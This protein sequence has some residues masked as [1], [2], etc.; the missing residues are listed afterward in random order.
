M[1]NLSNNQLDGSIPM[2]LRQKQEN[3]LLELRTENNPGLCTN[4]NECVDDR[5]K[6]KTLA[7][8]V[9]VVIAVILASLIL[10]VIIVVVVRRQ[11]RRKTPTPPCE[12]VVKEKSLNDSYL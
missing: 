1:L 12:L 4:G 9:I 11:R 5:G 8:A 7:T 2:D 10:L 6:K 3:G